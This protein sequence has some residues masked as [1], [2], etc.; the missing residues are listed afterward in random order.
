MINKILK[1]DTEELDEF[2]V[3][4][5]FS[6][7]TSLYELFDL[8]D[9]NIRLYL[10]KYKVQDNDKLER[11]SYELY[12]TTNYW[13]IILRLNDFDP[14]FDMSYDDDVILERAEY[15]AQSIQDD[16]LFKPTLLDIRKNEIISE[17]DAELKVTNEGFRYIWV[18]TPDK[19]QE[20]MKIILE[21]G[22]KW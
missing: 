11:I 1:F 8:T 17:L 20:F 15:Q 22:Y 2:I 9:V 10:S 5:Y 4:N 13:D 14:L 16:S 19:L 3:P 18:V 12:G 6:K 21:K 7:K